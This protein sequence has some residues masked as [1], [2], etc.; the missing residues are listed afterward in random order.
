MAKKTECEFIDNYTGDYT[1]PFGFMIH[2][3][4]NEKTVLTLSSGTVLEKEDCFNWQAESDKIIRNARIVT[5]RGRG[6]ADA[7]PKIEVYKYTFK[8]HGTY[9]GNGRSLNFLA[10][11]NDKGQCFDVMNRINTCP[12]Q[13]R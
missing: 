2:V 13:E 6:Y 9:F 8:E 12:K 3:L 7:P 4:D 11:W 5:V 10:I 1:F